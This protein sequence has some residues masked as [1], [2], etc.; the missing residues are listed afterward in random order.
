M[1]DHFEVTDRDGPARI[2]ELRFDDPVVTPA[3]VDE[4]D[5][6]GREAE[7]YGVLA[8]AG[9]RWAAE[10]EIPDGSPDRLTILPHRAF[11]GGTDDRVAESFAPAYPDVAYPSAAVVSAATDGDHGTDAYVLSETASILGHGAAAFEALSAVREAIPEDTALYAPGVATP[12][13]VATLAWAGVDLFDP[14]RALVKGRQGRYLTTDGEA[15]LAD[16]RELPCPCPACRTTVE[17]FDREDCVA[18]NVNALVGAIRTVRERIRNGQLRDY[19]DGQVRHEPWLTATVREYESAYEGLERRTPVFRDAEITAATEDAMRRIEIQ[20]FADRVTSRYRPRLDD[21]PLVLVPC[22]AAKPYGDSQSHGQLRG[23]IGFRAHKV[24][25]TSPI[26]VVPQELETTYPAQ[27]Y[28]SV[29]TGR[30]SA[31]EYE[32]V[33]RVLRR[34]L[35]R[36]DYPRIVA[37]VPPDYRPILDRVADD[38]DV[39][40]EYTVA[41]HPTT[42]DSLAALSE[43]LHGEPTFGRREREVAT[44]KAIADVQFGDGAGDDLFAA[45]GE[46]ELTGRYPRLQIRDGEGTQ[47]GTMVPQYGLLSFTVAGAQ[48]WADS[49]APTKRVAIDDFV[50]HGSVL[51]PG[52]VDADDVIRPGD[53][54]LIEGPNAVAVGRAKTHGAAMVESTRGVACSVRHA[55]E[56]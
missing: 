31:E 3:V 13:N 32:F 9:S 53:E 15:F 52:V 40:I 11:P 23:A 1:T 2:G 33:A 20:R 26:G 39:P 30:W 21:H 47:F 29:V 18:H 49:D 43:T 4:S 35:A 34:Y 28:D 51:A 42:D 6:E 36:T 55:E 44:L 10:R 56:R 46:V 27:H 54:V 25:I 5:R 14:H 12:A 45:F 19:L 38:V 22:S 37:H 8:D 50:P 48:R 7:P 24:S 41:D 16:L 17:A